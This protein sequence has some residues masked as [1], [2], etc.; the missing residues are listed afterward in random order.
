MGRMVL[1]AAAMTLL[2]ILQVLQPPLMASAATKGKMVTVLSVDGG[3]I[4]GVIPGTLLAFL[5]SKLQ[6]L[7]GPNARVADYFDVVAGTSTG[8]LITTMLTAPNKDNRPLYQ[9]K[10]ISNFYMEHGPQIFPQS[11][12]NSLLGGPKYDGKY[13]RT[14]I[15]LI[16]GNLTMKQT[17]TN[18]VIP[19]FNQLSSAKANISKNAQLSDICL[20]TSAAP[21]YFPVHYFETKDAQ[22]KIR[23][24]DLV[25]GGVAANNPTLMAITHVSK[26]IMTG[27]FQYEDMENMDCK[28]MLVLSL[29][30]GTGKHEEKY[31]AT[32]ASRWGMLGWVFNNGATPLIDVYGDASADMVDIHVSTMFQTLGS[33][34]NYIR[35]QDDNLTG[36]AASMDIAT[37]KNMERLVQIG[38]DLLKKPVSRVNLETGLYEPVVGEGTNEAA[39]VRF[40]QLL[41]EER[42]LRIDN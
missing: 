25:D 13:L 41:S 40:A 8:G 35:I 33:E 20:S 39:I 14:I 23:T 16:L 10:D 9:A 12:R 1:I 3:G 26:Q 27:N 37:T 21:T 4:R 36:E 30:T 28:K 31:N 42:K 24:F 34:K 7:D 6:E 17:L 29:G 11:R 32:M 18:T 15:N 5:E 38:N 2:V 22:G 19:T